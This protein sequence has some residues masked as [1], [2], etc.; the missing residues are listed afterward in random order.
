MLKSFGLGGI[1]EA[2]KKMAE[3]G[4]VDKI[5]AFANG[6]DELNE[7]LGRIEAALSRPQVQFIEG[8]HR[9]VEPGAGANAG[10]TEHHV[11]RDGLGFSRA[12]GSD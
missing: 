10:R 6:L 2:A 3:D 8:Q 12:N 9:P 11:G 7:R 5:L 4:T 1:V